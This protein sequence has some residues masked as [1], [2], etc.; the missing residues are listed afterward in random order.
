[1]YRKLRLDPGSGDILP[2][3]QSIKIGKGADR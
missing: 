1:V 3:D 2:T